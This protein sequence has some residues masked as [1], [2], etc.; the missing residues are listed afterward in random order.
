MVATMGPGPSGVLSAIERRPDKEERIIELRLEEWRTN[1][2]ATVQG[3]K[4]I[5]E[6]R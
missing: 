6:S 4:E 1:M 2:T 5:A 3:I